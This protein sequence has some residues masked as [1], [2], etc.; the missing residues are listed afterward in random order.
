[1]TGPAASPAPLTGARRAAAVAT[2]LAAMAMAVLDAGMTTMALPSLSRAFGVTP[3]TVVSVVTA[4]QAGLVIGLLPLGAA[5]ERFGARRVFRMSIG[6]FAAAAACAALAPSLPWLLAARFAQ[7]LGGAGIM[8]LGVALLRFAMPADRLGT[9]IGWN[10]LTVALAS[11]AAPSLGAVALAI[12]GWRGLFVL[13]LP[14]AALATF[15]GLALPATPRRAAPLD[16]TA[17]GLNGAAFGLLI[18]ALQSAGKD[19]GRAALLLAPAVIALGL[20]VR[21]EAPKATPLIPLDL[22]RAPPFR[23]SVLAS[24]SCFTAQSAGL[25]ALPFLLQSRL[26]LSPLEAGLCITAWPLGVAVAAL[27]SG[28][29]SDRVSTDRLCVLGAVAL[30]AGLAGCGLWPVETEAPAA[31]V[32]F[33]ALCGAGFGLFQSPNNRNLFLA[34]PPERS[35]AAGGLQGTARVSGQTLGT[36]AMALLLGRAPLESAVTAGFPLGAGLAGVAGVAS[37]MRGAAARTVS[38]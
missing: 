12:A 14:L 7:G 16:L 10:A 19:V 15:S 3:D 34:A 25:V 23:L 36:L 31:L 24:V 28:R 26:Q 13:G 22:L 9:A 17:M 30:A 11:A 35:G 38:A 4:Y 6:L 1:M 2:V 20:L 21:R 18:L 37:L 33:I 5:G 29:L 27:A 8:A 32:P